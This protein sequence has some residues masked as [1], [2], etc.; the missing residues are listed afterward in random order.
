MLMSTMS[1]LN[2]RISIRR[3]LM[4]ALQLSSLGHKLVLCLVRDVRGSISLP[5]YLLPNRFRLIV[6][7]APLIWD[8]AVETV[9]TPEYSLASLFLTG[10]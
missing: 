10:R 5:K 3:K 7:I 8:S 4:L 1:S 2:L 9:S 6:A